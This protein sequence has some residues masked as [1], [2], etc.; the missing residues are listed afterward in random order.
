M[1]PNCSKNVKI[2]DQYLMC[3]IYHHS[4]RPICTPSSATRLRGTASGRPV[5][6]TSTWTPRIRAAN[7]R[8]SCNHT[9]HIKRNTKTL[10]HTIAMLYTTLPKHADRQ[11]LPITHTAKKTQP[12]HPTPLNSRDNEHTPQPPQHNTR[13]DE[14]TINN[15]GAANKDIKPQSGNY[16]NYTPHITRHLSNPLPAAAAS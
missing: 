4:E 6:W 7:G 15:N 2:V 10:K 1:I 5:R 13:N 16:M 12:E 3:P 8:A 9:T 14:N 11:K